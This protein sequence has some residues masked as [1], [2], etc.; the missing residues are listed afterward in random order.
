MTMG[1]RLRARAYQLVDDAAG[2]HIR[3]GRSELLLPDR[4]LGALVVDLLAAF[5]G[6]AGVD[7]AA[8]VGTYA[9]R[10]NGVVVGLIDR[11]VQ[12][13]LLSDADEFC[14]DG[15]S[16]EPIFD[17]FVHDEGDYPGKVR[18]R[19]A[20]ASL[21]IL[22]VNAISHRLADA[23]RESAF[24][25]IQVVDDPPLR[26]L[27]LFEQN[28]KPAADP[29]DTMRPT[30]VAAWQLDP[31]RVDCLVATVEFGAGQLI[32]R[33]NALAVSLSVPF[34][35]ILLDGAVGTVGPLV[36]PGETAC[37]NCLISRENAPWLRRPL[38]IS[39]EALEYQMAQGH[40]PS[41]PAMLADCAAI[42]LTRFFGEIPRPRPG[43]VI[44]V[45][46]LDNAMNARRVLRI[47]RCNVCS[48]A[49]AFSPIALSPYREHDR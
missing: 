14:H 26:N 47:P 16:P 35:P 31:E 29:G 27:R 13:G 46:F 8:I 37:W 17:I 12:V 22:G 44:T 33:W 15:N 18:K 23:L 11:L 48:E 7:R 30:P 20:D 9:P 34:L 43:R 19:L 24:L 39:R 5:E 3:R 38:A 2:L 45:D 25:D 40:H 36:V 10:D 1:E 4:R 49:N 32:D 28:A 41:M 6:E 21:T 42:E